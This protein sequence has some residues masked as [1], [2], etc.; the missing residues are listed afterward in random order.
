MPQQ[1][2]RSP[3]AIQRGGFQ[4][5]TFVQPAQEAPATG[6]TELAGALGRLSPTLDRAMVTRETNRVDGL[7]QEAEDEAAR[8][9]AEFTGYTAEQVGEALESEPLAERFRQNPYIMPALQVHRGRVSADEMAQSMVEA[10]IDPGDPDA[11]NAY[12]QENAPQSDDAFFARGLNEQM[13][14][15]R[16]QWTQQQLR[17]TLEQA[18]TERRQAAGREFQTV[19]EDTGDLGAAVEALRTSELG[20][21]GVDITDILIGQMSTAAQRGDRDFVETLATLERDNGIPSLADDANVADDVARFREQADLRWRQ[22]QQDTWIQTRTD[23]YDV[24][25]TP[26]GVTR[27]ALETDPRFENL[28]E[29]MQAMVIERWRSDRNNRQ[30]QARQGYR[31]H[32]EASAREQF[33]QEA[34]DLL[35]TGRG[36]GIEDRRV[37]DEATGASVFMSR[38]QQIEAARRQFRSRYLGDNPLNVPAEEAH[39]YREYTQAL[40]DGDLHDPLL[41]RHLD[42]LGAMLTPE[43]MIEGAGEDVAQGYRMYA[44]MDPVTARR[45]V[46]DTRSRAVFETMDRLIQRD[47]DMEQAQAAE[48]AVAIVSQERPQIT[49]SSRLVRDAVRGLEIVDPLNSHRNWRFARRQ[50]E[51]RPEEQLARGWVADRASEYASY[52]GQEEALEMARTD[53]MSEHTVVHGQI[54][55]VPNGPV[56]DETHSRETP[57]SWAR[58]ATSYLRG[59]A[60]QAGAENAEEAEGFSMSH[61]GGNTYVIGLPDGGIRYVTAEQIRRGSYVY[62]Q[63][64]S[65]SEA[66][67]R[68][69]GN[70]EAAQEAIDRR[71]RPSTPT[72][73]PYTAR[74]F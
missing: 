42:G 64:L 51:V 15:F 49:D 58:T 34:F 65:A 69:E 5:G 25:D 74:P 62:D 20:L 54:V 11:V 31:G 39:R 8:I 46:T 67:T 71:N 32:F 43:G 6:L 40:A 14:R 36:E 7:R 52:M 18:E 47:P 57:E 55:G 12:L 26:E 16:A 27:R 53:Y 3:E 44:N 37:V 17:A 70:L 9:Q 72:T 30:S 29:N 68:A 61:A 48:R 38:N 41:Q 59:M 23:L 73:N 4:G 1:R 19:F 24:I 13:D 28:P 10:G 45:Y 56:S 66:A 2:L 35:V 60:E 33:S 22:N 21:R 63:Y 50:D